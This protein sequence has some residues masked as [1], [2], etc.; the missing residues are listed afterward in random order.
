MPIMGFPLR[1]ISVLISRIKQ[2][3]I[4]WPVLVV[5]R[6]LHPLV[7]KA[8][9]AIRLPIEGLE[10]QGVSRRKVSLGRM[11][12][13][14]V[15]PKLLASVVALCMVVVM[16]MLVMTMTMTMAMTAEKV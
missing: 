14:R 11:A 1:P 6:I 15:V 3:L 2:L 7:R 12:I 4:G 9:Q 16:V 10:A 8:R 5:M 13:L